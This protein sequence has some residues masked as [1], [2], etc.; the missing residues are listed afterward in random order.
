M[1]MPSEDRTGRTSRFEIG[2]TSGSARVALQRKARRKP[3]TKRT[4]DW[5][6][7]LGPAWRGMVVVVGRVGRSSSGWSGTVLRKTETCYRLESIHSVRLTVLGDAPMRLG[8]VVVEEGRRKTRKREGLRTTKR[9]W[10]CGANEC[11][12]GLLQQQV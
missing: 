6:N 12:V 3:Q 8:V 7:W 5:R 11:G 9:V 2:I 1:T 10:V 4:I